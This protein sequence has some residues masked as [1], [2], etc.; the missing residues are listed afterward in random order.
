MKA[1]VT[2][3]GQITIPK[4]IRNKANI[5]EGSELDFQFQDDNTIIIRLS[6]HPILE[7]KGIVKPKRKKPVSLKEMKKAIADGAARKPL[8]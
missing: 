7:L 8:K 2:S 6:T 1:T 4:F 3:K 5:S